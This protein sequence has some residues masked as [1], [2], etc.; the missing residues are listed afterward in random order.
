M[1]ASAALNRFNHV[2][3]KHDIL[4]L[5]N[6]FPHPLPRLRN[7]QNYQVDLNAWGEDYTDPFIQSEKRIF[8]RDKSEETEIR[9]AHKLVVSP[10]VVLLVSRSRRTRV[11]TRGFALG[12]VW[13]LP[14]CVARNVVVGMR[15]AATTKPAATL[16]IVVV[17]A[18]VVRF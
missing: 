9:V 10:K 18:A 12:L 6:S 1:P 4:G 8:P 17:G 2:L 11:D 5:A 7:T 3:S 15:V 16:V 14:G 13:T